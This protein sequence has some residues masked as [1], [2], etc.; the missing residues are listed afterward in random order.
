MIWSGEEDE[1][2]ILHYQKAPGKVQAD[3][4]EPCLEYLN[5]FLLHQFTLYFSFLQKI[6]TTE[7]EL[8][9]DQG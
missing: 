4:L 8:K 6:R 9:K 3:D 2:E 1:P 5:L 7:L